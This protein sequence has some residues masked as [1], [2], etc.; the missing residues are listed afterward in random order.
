MRSKVGTNL[1]DF[2]LFKGHAEAAG[3]NLDL[4]AEYY[5]DYDMNSFAHALWENKVHAVEYLEA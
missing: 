5:P 4:L 1:L 2:Q 3:V